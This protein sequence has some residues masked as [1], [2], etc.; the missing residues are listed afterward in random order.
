MFYPFNPYN[1]RVR[2]IDHFGIPIIKTIYVN[3][4]TTNETVTY[5]ICPR[6]WRQLP[7]EG[8]ILLNIT[9]SPASTV[10]AGSLVSI[11][12]TLTTSQTSSTNTTTSGAKAL[13]NGSGEQM[14][15]NEI[16]IGNKYLIYYNKC[17][18][19]FQTVN[20]IIPP[21]S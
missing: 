21:A 13:L 1:N 8:I 14:V 19:T 17:N 4:N 7:N 16:S 2:T 6:V 20:H 9:H 18:G 5:G 10:V 15:T 12:P 11:D 3:T